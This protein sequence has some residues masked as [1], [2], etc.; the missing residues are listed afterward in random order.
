MASRFGPGPTPQ[1]LGFIRPGEPAGEMSLMAGAPH[2]ADVIALRD[3]E[4]LALPRVMFL[5]EAERDPALMIELSRLLLARAHRP[6][7]P[8][9]FSA[10]QVFGFVAAS[11]AGPIRAE[12]QAMADAVARLGHSV[13][14]VGGEARDRPTEW[15]SN[16]E[17]GCDYI[18]YVAEWAEAAWRALASRQADRLFIVA[19]GGEAIEL[20]VEAAANPA[21]PVRARSRTLTGRPRD[22][23]S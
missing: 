4:V 10:A 3:C 7:V 11:N 15:F 9:P 5:A 19:R 16:L 14:V 2:S 21:P 22:A 20:Y 23:R 12:V 8:S 18:F 6:G 17:Q 13:T 1:R